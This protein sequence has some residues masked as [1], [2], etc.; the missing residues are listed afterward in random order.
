MIDDTFG[1]IF[2]IFFFGAILLLQYLSGHAFSKRSIFISKQKDPDE[3]WASIIL[4]SI[5]LA[6]S[7]IWAV[8]D[9]FKQK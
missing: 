2:I 8:I 6:I 9:F 7:I 5:L 1:F 3:Y 4:Q